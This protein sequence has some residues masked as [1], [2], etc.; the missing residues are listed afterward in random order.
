MHAELVCEA[1]RDFQRRGVEPD[2]W[3]LEPL[4][5]VDAYQAVAGV[6]RSGGRTD[7][8]CVLLGGGAS[9]EMAAQWVNDV[10]SVEGFNGFAIGRSIWQDPLRA[11]FDGG[12]GGEETT[13]AITARIER[14]VVAYQAT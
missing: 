5:S 1:V 10:R 7:V 13:Q 11:Y 3:K 4:P 12:G 14:L 2:V 8:G 9:I 6:C